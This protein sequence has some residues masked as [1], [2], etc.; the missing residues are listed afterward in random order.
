[1]S[2]GAGRA[3]QPA[4]ALP[5][6]LA[7]GVSELVL[8]FGV[9]MIS[10]YLYSSLTQQRSALSGREGLM[11]FEFVVLGIYFVWFWSHGGQTVAMRAWHIRLVGAD[12]QPVPQPRALARYLLSYVWVLPSLA[13]V[14]LVASAPGLGTIFGALALNIALWA[15]FSRLHPRRQFWHDAWCGTQL[16]DLRRPRAA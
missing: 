1:M 7:C 15:G 4:P 3:A 14:H 5:R 10:G 12:G 13:L 16:V 9:V 8:L 6:R 11:L 2:A